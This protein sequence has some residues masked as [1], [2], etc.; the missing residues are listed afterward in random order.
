VSFLRYNTFQLAKDYF[1][2]SYSSGR[3]KI[4]DAVLK[5]LFSDFLYKIMAEEDS[6]EEE[7]K[8]WHT[9]RELYIADNH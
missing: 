1:K 9:L 7:D 4:P 2:D 8:V 3:Q 5:S 6:E